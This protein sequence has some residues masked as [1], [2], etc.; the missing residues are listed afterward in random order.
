MLLLYKLKQHIERNMI[1]KKLDVIEQK[2]VVGGVYDVKSYGWYY[3]AKCG[4]CGNEFVSPF[5]WGGS[6][7][8]QYAKEKAYACELGDA[9]LWANR[10]WSPNGRVGF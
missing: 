4:Y 9:E 6:I 3:G 5:G 1:M 2:N 7:G 8:K 10:G